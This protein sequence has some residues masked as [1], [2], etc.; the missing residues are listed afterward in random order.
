MGL[1]DYI[2]VARRHWWISVA[3][4]ALALAVAMVVT[5]RTP[6][7]YASNVTFFFTTPSTMSADLYPASLFST[8]RLK[9]YAALLTSDRIT[10]PLAQVPGVGLTPEEI[11]QRI[12]SVAVADTVMLEVTVTDGS[13]SRAQLLTVALVDRFETE[14]RTLESTTSDG[15][16][17]VSVT[18]VAGPQLEDDPVEPRPLNNAA[19]AA[20]AGLVVGAALTVAR[21]VSDATIRTGD[22]LQALVSAPVLARV[23]IDA[24]APTRSGP[25]VSDNNSARAEALRQLRTNLQYADPDQRVQVVAVTSAVPGEGRSATACS[26]ALLFAESGRRVLIVDAE[27]RHPRLA[28]FLGRENSAG[29][30]TVLTGAASVEQVLQ[31]W[32]AGLWLLSTGQSPPNPSELLSSQRMTELVDELRGRFDIV[33]FDCPPLLPVTDAAVIAARSDGALLVVRSRK[34]KNAQ[35]T[36]AVRA[37]RAVNARIFGCVLNMVGAKSGE[38]FP[39]FHRYTNGTPPDAAPVAGEPPARTARN[40]WW[41]TW[42]RLRSAALGFAGVRALPA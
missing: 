18:V 21:E 7:L 33:I 38:A 28:S 37:L 8:A 42:V 31:P 14:V 13:P 27:L 34:T 16:P 41:G 19:L 4:I 35:V 30:S 23:P 3:S 36:T 39:N 24:S 17:T 9:S 10:Q 15:R 6:P 11:A 2:R 22:A 12:S 40:R 29:L 5:I 20:M 1:R 32:G 26:L 25:F